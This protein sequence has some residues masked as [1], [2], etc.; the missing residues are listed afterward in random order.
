MVPKGFLRYELLKKISEKPMSGSEI[1]NEL[2][3]E[4]NG[5]WKPSPG[6]IYPLLAWLQDQRYIKEADQTEPGTRRYTLTEEGKAFLETETKSREEINKHLEH[7]GRMWYGHR[8]YDGETGEAARD[9]FKAVREL[10]RELRRERPENTTLEEAMKDLPAVTER[11]REIT[12]KL[13]N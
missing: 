11:I 2:E 6:S 5:F 10:H 8:E 13:Q 7:F 12:K 9:L 4:T 1:M 3:N